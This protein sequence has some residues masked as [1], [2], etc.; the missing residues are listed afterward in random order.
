M[1]CF[2]RISFQSFIETIAEISS[3]KFTRL[4]TEMQIIGLSRKELT[5]NGLAFIEIDINWIE[6]YCIWLISIAKNIAIK[7]I[8]FIRKIYH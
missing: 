2:F 4:S 7:S 8:E 5:F 6:F 1:F 3:S